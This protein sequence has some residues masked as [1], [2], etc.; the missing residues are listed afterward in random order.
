MKIKAKLKKQIITATIEAYPE[1]MCGV[2]VDDEFVRLPNIS[3][4]A[5]N[6]F[7]I[8]HKA[9]AEIEDRGEIQA[10]V[11][12]HPDGTAVASPLDQHQIE[13]HGK[14]W[15]ICAYPDTDVQVFKPTGYK[16]PLLGRHYFHGWQD[17]YSLVRDFY[18]RELGITLDDFERDD[19]WWESQDHA[20]LYLENYEKAGFYEVSQ[21]KYGDMIICKVGRTEHPNHAVIWLGDKSQF[22]SEQV[23]PC[24]GSSLI[25]HH[26]YSRISERTIYGPNWAE[27]TVKILRHKDVQNNSISRSA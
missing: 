4:D 22:K 17:C 16:A 19:R 8:D 2:V 27:R 12:S 24:F 9:L 21:P 18:E 15:I 26:P 1:E 14:P 20:S 25:L 5:K 3:K 6:H 13:L 11:H 10:Y 23:D 7:E